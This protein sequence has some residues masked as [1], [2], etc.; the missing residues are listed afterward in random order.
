MIFDSAS[1]GMVVL[2]LPVIFLAVLHWQ[3]ALK[4]AHLRDPER[5]TF[6]T[7]ASYGLGTPQTRRDR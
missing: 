1:M 4:K 3:R 7:S 2:T 6:S 5:H